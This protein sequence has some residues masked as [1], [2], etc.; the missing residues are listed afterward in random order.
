MVLAVLYLCSWDYDRFRGI[1]T[2]RPMKPELRPVRLELDPLERIGFI[3]FAA[4]LFGFFG[5]TRG[6]GPGGVGLASIAAVAGAY[7]K[8]RMDQRKLD[9]RKI[10][11]M[12]L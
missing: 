4:S 2:E 11:R 10:R 9:L 5:L 8:G 7:A 1:F 12:G 3:V 6:F